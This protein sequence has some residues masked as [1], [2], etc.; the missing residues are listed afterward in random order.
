MLVEPVE[1]EDLKLAPSEQARLL[2]EWGTYG[3]QGPIEDAGED[4][5]P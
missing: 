5:F 2:R 1:V 3:P 4:E